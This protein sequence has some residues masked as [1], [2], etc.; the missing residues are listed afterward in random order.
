[1]R[2]R[3]APLRRS[4]PTALALAAALGCAQPR[5]APSSPETAG[6]P[7]PE[8][9][10]VVSREEIESVVPEWVAS[11]VEADPDREEAMRLAT[12]GGDAE[13][14]VF[15]GTW[16]SDSRRELSRFWRALDET[17]GEAAFTVRYIGVDRDKKEPREWVEG[18]DL[19]FVPTFIVRREG[20]EI[21]RIVEES[22]NGIEGDLLALLDGS[23][24]GVISARD[25]LD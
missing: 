10:G 18:Q 13:V 5:P 3:R 21:G 6:A 11:L 20:R 12:A 14:D 24:A 9:V 22:P 17:G 4:L 19:R 16:C 15:L 23:A 1:M 2:A 8:L 25:D 7:D